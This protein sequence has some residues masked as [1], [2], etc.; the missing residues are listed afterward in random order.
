MIFGFF[1]IRP[2]PLPEATATNRPHER[3]S[4]ASYSELPHDGFAHAAGVDNVFSPDTIVYEHHPHND[5]RANLLDGSTQTHE[6]SH[7]LEMAVSPP[8][9]E[10]RHRS[11]SGP[12]RSRVRHSRIIEVMQELY[13]KALWMS[14]D[15]WLLFVLLSL[16]ESQF[17]VYACC[18]NVTCS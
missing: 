16:R 15:F 12:G 17:A 13:G 7:S 1:L 6:R 8:P 10:R 14:S 4:N 3:H 18:A 5:S 11:L 2:I 9:T